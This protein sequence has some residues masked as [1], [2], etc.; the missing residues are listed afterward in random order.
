MEA[1]KNANGSYTVTIKDVMAE[2][3]DVEAHQVIIGQSDIVPEKFRQQIPERIQL[4]KDSGKANSGST[5]RKDGV[6]F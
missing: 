4:E 6:A 3:V 1:K 2:P 5:G